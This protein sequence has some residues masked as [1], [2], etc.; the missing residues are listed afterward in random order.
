M[1]I[2]TQLPV[3]SATSAQPPQRQEE[4]GRQQMLLVSP[5]PPITASQVRP[6]RQVFHLAA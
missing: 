2:D 6:D 3:E 5:L 1:E 4:T